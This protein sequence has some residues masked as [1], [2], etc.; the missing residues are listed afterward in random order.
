[1]LGWPHAGAV[2][3]H[4]RRQPGLAAAD[5]NYFSFCELWRL[6][7][8]REYVFSEPCDQPAEEDIMTMRPDERPS[9]LQRTLAVFV[10]LALFLIL[11]LWAGRMLVQRPIENVYL[12]S[13]RLAALR[14]FERA[15][16]PLKSLR[17]YSAPTADLIRKQF[18]FCAD[19]LQEQG[20]EAVSARSRRTNACANTSAAEELAC[21]LRT[22]N[23]RLN[24][25]SDR[26]NNRERILSEHYVVDVDR[27][28]DAIRTPQR[29]PVVV[30]AA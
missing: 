28:A 10:V 18:D 14:T 13:H 24:E 5:G 9:L 2:G 12:D 4:G 22:I 15:I 20:R 26:R 3:D 1:M 27:W 8:A 17:D 21:H 23:S 11:F 16:V 6:V 25:M 19:P 30:T 29:Q 7:A